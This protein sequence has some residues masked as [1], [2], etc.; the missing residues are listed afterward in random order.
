MLFV[1]AEVRDSRIAGKGLFLRAPVAKGTVVS[2]HGAKAQLLTQ[3]EYQEAQRQGHELAIRTG[4]RWVGRYFLHATEMP[5]EAYLNHSDDPALLYHCGI[6]FARRDLAVG[7]ELTVDYTL[8]LAEDDV[9]GFEDRATGRMLYGLPP[10]D[11]LLRSAEELVR[12][13]R[14]IDRIP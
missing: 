9:E 3:A 5:P 6:S 14:D 7:D 2:I 12:I 8:F 10:R 11:S 1:D 4:I 13:L